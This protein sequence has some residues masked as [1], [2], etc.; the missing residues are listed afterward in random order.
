MAK[1]NHREN[2]Q[3]NQ[4]QNPQCRRR[5]FE[6]LLRQREQLHLLCR[7]Q[8]QD[9]LPSQ[10]TRD[11]SCREDKQLSKA[12]AYNFA[13]SSLLSDAEE[14]LDIL[15]QEE[16]SPSTTYTVQ[17]TLSLLQAVQALS[18]LQRELLFAIR[19]SKKLTSSESNQTQE[20]L[21]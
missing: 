17:A 10:Q 3:R 15:S 13:I 12:L 20:D 4:G 6:T 21:Q 5:S 9:G 8:A 2:R 7:R 18:L 19:H 16:D 1:G 11:P 14:V